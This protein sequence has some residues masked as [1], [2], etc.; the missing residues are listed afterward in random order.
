MNSVEAELQS[1]ESI[2]CQDGEFTVEERTVDLVKLTIFNSVKGLKFQC[3]LTKNYPH[4][5]P[6]V[7]VLIP[8]HTKSQRAELQ[9]ELESYLTQNNFLGEP[10]LFN[11]ISWV[12]DKQTDVATAKKSEISDEL[13]FTTLLQL[14][15]MRS[16][17]KYLKTLK[18]WTSELNING[19]VAFYIRFIFIGLQGY[20]SNLKEFVHR[21]K[22]QKIDVDSKGQPCKEKMMKVL[23][24]IEAR[25]SHLN[26]F[27][28]FE[29][30]STEELKTL[31][32]EI[33]LSCQF[34][35][36]VPSVSR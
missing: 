6:L 32:S 23:C 34:E 20:S 24:P 8:H 11:V 7:H 21:I 19:Y 9:A 28:V 15:H 17:S 30:T 1:L 22:T 35:N 2:F 4:T 26:E 29:L 5:T 10:M 14:D 16:K 3:I 13:L 18:S 12:M 27:N 36:Y 33:G 25:E 31:F